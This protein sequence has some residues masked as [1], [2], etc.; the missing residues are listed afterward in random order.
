MPASLQAL[1]HT[2]AV[3]QQR[4]QER[5]A[6][7]VAELEERGRVQR[8]AMLDLAAAAEGLARE[9]AELHARLVA[10]QVWAGRKQKN[11]AADKKLTSSC[12]QG[13]I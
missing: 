11:G 6:A 10:L 2:S 12:G 5:H 1:R 8:R 4:S 13:T 9:N 7:Q 3:R